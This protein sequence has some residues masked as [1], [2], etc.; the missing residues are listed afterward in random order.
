VILNILYGFIFFVLKMLKPSSVEGASRRNITPITNTN[1][2]KDSALHSSN[3]TNQQQQQQN[4]Q[5]LLFLGNPSDGHDGIHNVDIT[6]K[7]IR[8]NAA[9]LLDRGSRSIISNFSDKYAIVIGL[10]FYDYYQSYRV[11][12]LFQMVIIVSIVILL[13]SVLKYL[14]IQCYSPEYSNKN[15]M[16]FSFLEDV[17]SNLNNALVVIDIKAFTQIIQQAIVGQYDRMAVDVLVIAFIVPFLVLKSM[18]FAIYWLGDI[19]SKVTTPKRSSQ[20]VTTQSEQEEE[21]HKKIQ[22]F[23]PYIE[24]FIG[25]FS[26]KYSLLLALD[27]YDYAT[28]Y[29]R[30]TQFYL[31]WSLVGLLFILCLTKGTVFYLFEKRHLGQHILWEFTLAVVNYLIQLLVIIEIKY[32]GTVIFD[33]SSRLMDGFSGYSLVF[34]LWFPIVASKSALQLKQLNFTEGLSEFVD[35]FLDKYIFLVSFDI[36]QQIESQ[37]TLSTTELVFILVFINAESFLF[38]NF[39]EFLLQSKFLGLSAVWRFFSDIFLYTTHVVVLVSLKSFA[40]ALQNT[41]NRSQ[42]WSI[43]MVLLL[44]PFVSLHLVPVF[45]RKIFS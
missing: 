31:A 14:I 30:Y 17:L 40:T 22:T 4:L 28:F 19:Q 13:A 5:N 24:E 34:L 35:A 21:Q 37:N 43:T 36:Y 32:F 26:E 12:Y 25:N 23:L 3:T 7:H 9:Q 39:F 2:T 41:A 15:P 42:F 45:V 11:Y 16:L 38:E 6:D 29:S 20:I 44:V 8:I 10:V 27:L 18:P 33:V 1:V